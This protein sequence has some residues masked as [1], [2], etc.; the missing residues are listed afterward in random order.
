MNI[1]VLVYQFVEHS[2]KNKIIKIGGK[3]NK[4]VL[5]MSKMDH[6]LKL[7]QKCLRHEK[8]GLIEVNCNQIK[9]FLFMQFA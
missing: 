5:L 6:F 9:R 2:G 7:I 3:I 1:F 8:H 4:G